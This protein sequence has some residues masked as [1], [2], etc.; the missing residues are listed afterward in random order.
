MGAIH[1]GFDRRASVLAQAHIDRV[2]GDGGTVPDEAWVKT[3]ILLALRGGWFYRIW[4]F[5][6]VNAGYKS[7][8]EGDDTF[9]TRLYSLHGP[10]N[11]ATASDT[12][13]PRLAEGAVGLVMEFNTAGENRFTT[14]INDTSSFGGNKT[15]IGG[16]MLQEGTRQAIMGSSLGNSRAFYHDGGFTRIRFRAHDTTVGSILTSHHYDDI[17]E[18]EVVVD[19]HRIVANL[20][21]HNHVRN[22]YID[23]LALAPALG[24]GQAWVNRLGY[25]GEST[26]KGDYFM[27][28]RAMKDIGVDEYEAIVDVYDNKDAP[29]ESAPAGDAGET[30]SF[31]ANSTVVGHGFTDHGRGVNI[32][33]LRGLVCSKNAS[34]EG[35]VLMWLGGRSLMEINVDTGEYEEYIYSASSLPFA[36]LLA[37]D[38]KYYT[39]HGH[40]VLVF[41]PATST[42]S[43]KALG[44]ETLNAH[45]MYED[46]NGWIWG[47]GKAGHYLLAIW[48]YDP[49]LDV[50]H[51]YGIVLDTGGTFRPGVRNFVGDDQSWIYFGI[52]G[53]IE[54]IYGFKHGEAAITDLGAVGSTSDFYRGA[55]GKAYHDRDGTWIELYNGVATVLEEAPSTSLSENGF[56]E[57]AGSQGLEQRNLPTSNER[58]S[59][60]FDF[61]RIT[62][63]DRDT[64]EVNKIIDFSW[65][66]GTGEGDVVGIVGTLEGTVEG[67]SIYPWRFWS[68]NPAEDKWTVGT[69]DIRQWNAT[70]RVDD[71]LLYSGSYPGRGFSMRDPGKAYTRPGFDEDDNPRRLTDSHFGRPYVW[72]NTDI[73]ASLPDNRYVVSCGYS[74]PEEPAGGL[75]VWDRNT[76]SAEMIKGGDLFHGH[77]A[78]SLVAL[79]DN[80]FLVGTT[81]FQWLAQEYETVA[82]MYIIDIETKVIEWEGSPVADA[83]TY[84]DMHRAPDG[85]VYLIVTSTRHNGGPRLFVFDLSDNTI[86]TEISIPSEL[87]APV[88]DNGPR[89]FVETPDERVFMLFHHG[90]A[91]IDMATFSLKHATAV[92][93]GFFGPED[94]FGANHSGA[95]GVVFSLT[96]E[97]IRLT[98]ATVD[99][100]GA[101]NRTFELW[102]YDNAIQSPNDG[103]KVDEVTLNLADGEQEITLDL[104]TDGQGDYWVGIPGTANL[105]R[106]DDGQN[107]PFSA[108]DFGLEFVEGRR[109]DSSSTTERWY[110]IFGLEVEK[111][112]NNETVSRET[113]V[114][115]SLEGVSAFRKGGDYL[116]GRIYL[117]DNRQHLWSWE[118]PTP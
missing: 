59:V 52:D 51:D 3:L 28:C 100:N 70:V 99:A 41:D 14:E 15:Y 74:D 83:R 107:Y 94:P 24:D 56:E 116:D 21:G 10:G 38:W 81:V 61:R 96:D 44:S 5:S 111:K 47:I 30:L 39:A 57:A 17:M 25:N 79:S 22:V 92:P 53:D 40:K 117:S 86:V 48:A 72:R 80:K 87:G 65:N 118:V 54:K 93:S 20:W 46:D 84:Y 42:F 115:E 55:D 18:N 108:L 91:E 62:V 98:K 104:E 77:N 2:V 90:I 27:F 67:G 101:G 8:T 88:R 113:A 23:K 97:D 69:H 50:V 36:S 64:N 45:S 73:A 76:D 95:W 110:Y 49:N 89:V 4:H 71:G 34:D 109:I 112:A 9:V 82:K 26:G 75:I 29:E 68:F 66:D 19:T 106:S 85:Y 7:V 105:L 6:D 63:R 114:V 37:S 78:H 102:K 16:L 11:D 103:T 12:R 33:F 58:V 35:I 1:R 60:N 32:P 43:E 31:P 13:R